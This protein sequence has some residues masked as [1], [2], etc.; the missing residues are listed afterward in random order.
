M[1]ALLFLLPAFVACV[2]LT[3]IHTYL[4]IH[5]VRRGIIFVDIALAQIAALGM[6]VALGLGF[7]EGSPWVYFFGLLFTACGSL[8]FSLFRDEKIPQ[9]SLI[10][11]AFAVSSALAIVVADH[12]SHGA[13][14]LKEILSGNILWVTWPQILKTTCI[15]SLMGIFHFIFRKNFLLVSSDPAQAQSQG[16]KVWFWDLL[17]YLSFGII[18]TSS[19]QIA[20]VLLV[21]SFLI[22]PTLC[23]ILFFDSL[24]RRLFSGWGIGVL[25][26]LVG[27]LLS[28]WKDLPTGPAIV[29]CFGFF[30]GC[31]LIGRKVLK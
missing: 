26:S 24:K 14:H 20:G 13:E 27:I 21:F 25:V 12:M 30:L 3:G 16:L 19:V 10:G 2:L 28:L 4:G 5:V 15:Y 18:I 29:V 7:E 9:E 11:V 17:F 22:V 8:L 31:C 1:N 23:S 6:I